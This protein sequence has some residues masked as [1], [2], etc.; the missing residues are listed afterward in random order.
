MAVDFDRVAFSCVWLPEGF[1]DSLTGALGAEQLALRAIW[2][3]NGY[4]GA[5]PDGRWVEFGRITLS[6][7]P[8]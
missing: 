4:Q 8:Q 6:N 3:P 5:P 2:V 1:Q 7:E